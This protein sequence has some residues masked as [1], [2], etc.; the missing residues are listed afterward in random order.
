MLAA[1][2]GSQAVNKIIDLLLVEVH[3]MCI[4][5]YALFFR[6]CW[7]TW[8]DLV[9]VHVKID[10][11][12]SSLLLPLS[13]SWFL[14]RS[15]RRTWWITQN[16]CTCIFA[17]A[18][19]WESTGKMSSLLPSILFCSIYSHHCR[20]TLMAQG[21]RRKNCELQN[22]KSNRLCCSLYSFFLQFHNLYLILMSPESGERRARR[23][24]KN[25][26]LLRHRELSSE[27]VQV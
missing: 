16:T 15:S 4:S 8:R 9:C 14:A 3:F 23:G 20:W 10:S 24:W 5:F 13:S 7:W 25:R 1:H 6:C 21:G 19:S 18:S 26:I 2:A 27:N 22:G 11:K 17:A 12:V